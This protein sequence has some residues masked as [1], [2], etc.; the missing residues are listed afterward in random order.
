MTSRNNLFIVKSRCGGGKTNEALKNIK[1]FTIYAVPT[2]RLFESIQQ[3]SRL[4]FQSVNSV[5]AK[6]NVTKDLVSLVTTQQPYILCTHEGVSRLMDQNADLSNYH[7]IIDE[8][9]NLVEVFAHAYT[10]TDAQ[11]V[12]GLVRNNDNCLTS[13]ETKEALSRKINDIESGKSTNT[14]MLSLYR[15]L[16]GTT[17]DEEK[18]ATV[19]QV[20]D[21]DESFALGVIACRNF[22]EVSDRFKTATI[23]TADN[24]EKGIGCIILVNDIQI[25]CWAMSLEQN[26]TGKIRVIQLTDKSLI[27]KTAM[28]KMKNGKTIRE[29]M[30]D[31]CNKFKAKIMLNNSYKHLVDEP[32]PVISHGLNDWSNE[33]AIGCVYAAMPNPLVTQ[34]LDNWNKNARQAWV[35]TYHLD[36]IHQALA[37]GNMRNNGEQIC[38]V[39]DAKSA[40]YI[41]SRCVNAELD[42]SHVVTIEDGRISNGK[43]IFKDILGSDSRKF[44][45]WWSKKKKQNKLPSKNS[46]NPK[47]IK[48]AHVFKN[49]GGRAATDYLIV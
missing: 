2:N 32:L 13:S 44:D 48:L 18:S 23:M 31:V 37:R 10:A 15:G 46:I 35:Q 41:M 4:P 7:L 3:R 17:F 14:C 36:V 16:Y 42:L 39:P 26:Y 40:E 38:L 33:K 34:L 45:N 9:P 19:L 49:N 1:P 8:Q 29:H 5:N 47:H 25:P 30:V 12:R 43:N 21:T 6:Q 22:V 11:Y 28:D 24:I 27:S 20:H